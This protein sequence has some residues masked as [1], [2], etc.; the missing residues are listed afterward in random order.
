V[1]ALTPLPA[2]FFAAEKERILRLAAKLRLPAIYEGRGF[3]EAGGLM[4]Y[5]PNRRDMYR[6]A[7][8]QVDRIL[9]G[10]KPAEIPVEQATTIEFV[11]NE[12]TAKS[13]GVTFSQPI[14]NRA[15]EVIK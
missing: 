8:A 3:V 6:R 10:A 14:L 5:G 13:L 12:K 15:D 7:A 9:R 1:N 4:S 2:P 11:L